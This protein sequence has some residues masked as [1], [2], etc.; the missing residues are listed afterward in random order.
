LKHNLN[1]FITAIK[2]NVTTPEEFSYTFSVGTLNAIDPVGI[3]GYL[4]SIFEFYCDCVWIFGDILTALL[5]F[6]L[7]RYFS[8]LNHG[9]DSSQARSVQDVEKLRMDHRAMK[10]LVEV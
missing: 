1:L 6:I 10:D 5:S 9:I 2:N 8:R 3:H 4:A 7:T